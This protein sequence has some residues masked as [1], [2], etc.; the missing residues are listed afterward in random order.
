[1]VSDWGCFGMFGMYSVV[2]CLSLL[3]AGLALREIVRHFYKVDFRNRVLVCFPFSCPGI[4]GTSGHCTE[5]P[6][7][8]SLGFRCDSLNCFQNLKSGAYAY[9]KTWKA[10]WHVSVEMWPES[11]VLTACI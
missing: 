4:R 3:H 7:Y 1:M 8:R 10:A 9:A 2:S 6:C 5:V 11:G